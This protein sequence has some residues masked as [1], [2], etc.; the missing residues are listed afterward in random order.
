MLIGSNTFLYY[1][2]IEQEGSI[3]EEK[4]VAFNEEN[5]GIAPM[6]PQY[7]IIFESSENYTAESRDMTVDFISMLKDNIK[8]TYQEVQGLEVQPQIS[9]AGAIPYA[10]GQTSFIITDQ[11]LKNESDGDFGVPIEYLFFDDDTFETLFKLYNLD[12]TQLSSDSFVY[13]RQGS[14]VFS[15]LRNFD[16]EEEPELFYERD[17]NPISTAAQGAVTIGYT[18]EDSV[19]T[20]IG[21]DDVTGPYNGTYSSAQ[22][23]TID[24]NYILD[25]ET[26]FLNTTQSENQIVALQGSRT[27]VYT[28]Q[29]DNLDPDVDAIVFGEEEPK[30]RKNLV[31]GRLNNIAKVI[32]S[33]IFSQISLQIGI[34]FTDITIEEY[35]RFKEIDPRLWSS[36]EVYTFEAG[37]TE[38]LEKYSSELIPEF[39][40]MFF[41][42]SQFQSESVIIDGVEDVA[43]IS[44]FIYFTN[45]GVYLILLTVVSLSQVVIGRSK[46]RVL[47]ILKDRGYTTFSL[48]LRGL[49]G[50]VIYTGLGTLIALSLSF[51]FL[52][53]VFRDSNE[54]VNYAQSSTFSILTPLLIVTVI[55]Q[56]IIDWN[57]IRSEDRKTN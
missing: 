5:I 19:S 14:D 3:F 22:N 21:E 52:F 12:I 23:I 43:L 31:L 1:F 15:S 42:T 28:L 20:F 27:S 51:G 10:T 53:A 44:E 29:S 45:V 25:I 46:L 37:I 35:K 36:S 13:I 17:F 4:F 47:Q 39:E 6:T 18:Y 56:I 54:I 33:G 16:A 2:Q 34:S 32:P 26:L 8:Q 30:G 7:N 57:Y 50:S 24:P 55:V 38:F 40:R 41:Y 9:I 48:F 11:S 49:A